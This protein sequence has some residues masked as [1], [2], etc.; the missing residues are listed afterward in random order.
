MDQERGQSKSK[1]A[2][3]SVANPQVATPN[4]IRHA[5]E[6]LNQAELTKLGAFSRIFAY[7]IR[8]YVWGFGS[9][10]L[11][12]QAVVSLLDGK[13]VWE[14]HKVDLVK[15]LIEAMR[16]IASNLKRKG[17]QTEPVPVLESDLVVSDD[18]QP[19]KRNPFETAIERGPG[20]E[21]ELLDKE[22]LSEE[23]L[24]RQIEE[25]FRDDDVATLVLSGWK[26]GMGG[27]EIMDAIGIDRKEFDAAV[28]KIRR[29]CE[30]HWP[31]GM[32]Y[33]R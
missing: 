2:K 4:E 17:I 10:D 33:V 7:R 14:P 20:P 30:K 28:R 13:R 23:Q 6:L 27:P 32:P 8:H 22:A 11:L 12:Q 1:L 9:G 31:K 24:I 26:D 25:L 3:P 16:S 15:L 18:E 21:K 5:I 19:H 29:H